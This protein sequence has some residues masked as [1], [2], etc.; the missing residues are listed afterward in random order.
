MAALTSNKLVH[1]LRRRDRLLRRKEEEE[2]CKEHSTAVLNFTR[3]LLLEVY[4]SV[5]G[6]TSKCAAKEPLPLFSSDV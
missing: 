4:K 3:L 6:S 5:F 1:V 2:A